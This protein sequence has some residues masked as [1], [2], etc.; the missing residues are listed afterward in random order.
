MNEAVY[1]PPIWFIGWHLIACFIPL[2]KCWRTWSCSQLLAQFSTCPTYP[3]RII[4]Y[5]S[6]K[7]LTYLLRK[8]CNRFTADCKAS[9][10]SLELKSCLVWWTWRDRWNP[11]IGCRN[12]SRNSRKRADWNRHLRDPRRRSVQFCVII[13]LEEYPIVNLPIDPPANPQKYHAVERNCT[14]CP[15]VREIE[16]SEKLLEFR[17][18]P[19]IWHAL[20]ISIGFIQT[21]TSGIMIWRKSVWMKLRM[22]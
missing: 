18:I 17:K 6:W 10:S 1:V 4:C 7:R 3:P 11:A 9:V 19:G 12:S 2:G 15:V 5:P 8:K 13:Y 20:C 16:G 14:G 22:N 21:A